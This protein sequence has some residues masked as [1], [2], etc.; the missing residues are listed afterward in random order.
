MHPFPHVEL[1]GYTRYYQ[2]HGFLANNSLSPTS[3]DLDSKRL[4]SNLYGTSSKRHFRKRV[5]PGVVVLPNHMASLSTTSTAPETVT[6]PSS[7]SPSLST[8][9]S[10]LTTSSSLCRRSSKAALLVIPEE[11]AP[12]TGKKGRNQYQVKNTSEGSGGS[13]RKRK[14][15]II[16]RMTSTEYSALSSDAHFSVASSLSCTLSSASAIAHGSIQTRGTRLGL[17]DTVATTLDSDVGR[18][19]CKIADDEWNHYSDDDLLPERPDSRSSFRTA[20]S[21]FSD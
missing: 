6:L 7:A 13:L 3:T 10:S 5:K 19:A 21:N 14:R 4:T 17:Q 16:L 15:R 20:K 9:V 2:S 11:S 1:G 18:T 12:A 8:C